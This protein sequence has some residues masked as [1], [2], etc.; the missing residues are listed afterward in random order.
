MRPL[1]PPPAGLSYRADVLRELDG[2]DGSG[3]LMMVDAVGAPAH[4]VDAR[5]LAG[6]VARWLR[7]LDSA[8]VEA[9]WDVGTGVPVC[10]SPESAAF[11]AG[12]TFSHGG[13]G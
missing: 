12:W 8:G 10:Q 5:R 6:D 9:A 13:S 1:A 7:C 3:F 2:I 11:R 4:P